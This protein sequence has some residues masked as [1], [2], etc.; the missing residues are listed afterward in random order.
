MCLEFIAFSY[1]KAGPVE[2]SCSN[3]ARVSAKLRETKFETMPQPTWCK[4]VENRSNL[5]EYVRPF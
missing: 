5:S 3:I 2:E 4:N 1:R